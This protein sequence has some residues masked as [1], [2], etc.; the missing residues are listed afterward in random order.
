MACGLL[1]ALAALAGWSTYITKLDMRRRQEADAEPESTD[2]QRV[3]G[4]ANMKLVK[5][6][7]L[8]GTEGTWTSLWQ[9]SSYRPTDCLN[10]LKVI[11][12]IWIILGHSFLITGGCAGY[13]NGED[14]VK[15]LL[16][17]DAAMTSSIW[18]LLDMPGLDLAVDTF[19]FISGFLASYVGSTRA[20][21]LG[22]NVLL[23]YLRLAPCLAFA[24]MIYTLIVPFMVAGPFAPR[25]QEAIFRRCHASTWWTPLVFIMNFLPWYNDDVCMGWT[26]YLGNDMI[27]AII[28][29]ALLNLW[30]WGP[31]SGWAT[32]IGIAVSS[33]VTTFVL[34]WHYKLAI[35]DNP[36]DRVHGEDYQYYLYDK[37]WSRIP[38]YLVGFV[39]P[40][41]LLWAKGKYGLE[42]G[43]QPRSAAAFAAVRVAFWAAIGVI[44]F[45]LFITLSDQDGGFG[46]TR[47]MSNWTTPDNAFYLTFA[48]PVWACAHAVI[49]V[50]CFFDYLPIANGFLS[51]WVWAPLARL[52]YNAY[53]LHP[54]VINLRCGLAV[55]YYQFSYWTLFQNLLTDSTLAYAAAAV[56]WCLVEKPTATLTGFLL[57]KPTAKPRPPA[58]A[59]PVPTVQAAVVH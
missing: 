47:A 33:F 34:I 51:H 30:K 15:N 46:S 40:W 39:V 29:I 6:F 16:N 31:R 10:G 55:Q 44:F 8:V 23:R 22:R 13:F 42:R 3:I 4:L 45:L 9:R 1:V 49:A 35:I 26:W 7:S 53:L 14:V 59:A 54:L 56:M 52:T 27:F 57:A 11:S 48:R 19:F 12:M 18:P 50:A 43:T 21:P 17:P 58:A 24:M 28:G 25:A 5:A 2:E 41:L 36:G 37:P 20:T 38:A 32:T